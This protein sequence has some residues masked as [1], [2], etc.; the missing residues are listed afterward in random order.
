VTFTRTT[1]FLSKCYFSKVILQCAIFSHSFVFTLLNESLLSLH[2]TVKN[3]LVRIFFVI[4]DCPRAKLFQ[5]NYSTQLG[6]SETDKINAFAFVEENMELM[7]DLNVIDLI[8]DAVKMHKKVRKFYS[9]KVLF[10]K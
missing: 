5:I 10:S 6:S 9:I 8:V 1:Y 3:A 7:E 4:L 2:R